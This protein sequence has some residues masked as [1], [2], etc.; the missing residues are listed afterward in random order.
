MSGLILNWGIAIHS[1]ENCSV[2]KRGRVL[3]QLPQRWRA[4]WKQR[5]RVAVLCLVDVKYH[6]QKQMK[7]Q[8][9]GN[10]LLP[11]CGLLLVWWECS[12]AWQW[13]HEKVPGVRSGT[14]PVRYIFTTE[15]LPRNQKIILC[16]KSYQDLFLLDCV[17]TILSVC[18]FTTS[19][20]GVLRSQ[21]RASYPMELEL[22]AVINHRVGAGI[23]IWICCKS[24]QCP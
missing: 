8:G 7:G 3:S 23:G 2:T 6:Q 5:H 16:K 17:M 24:S 15:S 9:I 18:L 4:E 14:F 1:M 20:P 21:K 19:M 22:P 13:L 12:R 10:W 11:V